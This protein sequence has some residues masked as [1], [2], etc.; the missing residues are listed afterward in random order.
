M[1]TCR[2]TEVDT[3]LFLCDVVGVGLGE[4]LYLYKFGISERIG[5]SLEG[6]LFLPLNSDPS[7]NFFLFYF[8][9]YKFSSGNFKQYKKSVSI[10]F[11]NQLIK[12]ATR[13]FPSQ[14]KILANWK[15]W[16]GL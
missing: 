3:R 14:P 5:V 16:S 8:F 12:L 6:S 1:V 2:S 4:R 13:R 15:A 7:V 9:S 11:L 10:S